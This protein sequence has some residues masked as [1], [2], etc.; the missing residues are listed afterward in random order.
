M[1]FR[2]PAIVFSA[3]LVLGGA[4]AQSNSLVDGT[5]HVPVTPQLTPENRGDIYMARKMYREAI[6]TFRLGSPT[7]AVLQNKIGIAYHQLSRLDDARKAYER[8]L[9]LNPTYVEAMNNL[10]T[11]YYAKKS[12][13]RAI[14]WYN[15]ALKLAPEQVKSAPIY[16]NLG[17]AW[18]ARKKYPETT[19]AY[20]HALALDPDVFERHGNFGV[21]LEERTVEERARY[22]L[23]LAKLYAKDGRNELALQYLRKA[24]EEGIKEKKKLDQEPEFAKL[25]NTPEF[26]QLMATEQRVL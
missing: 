6:E 18:F 11:V 23:Y 26:K 1:H 12:Y 10:G 15:K 9:R 7:S 4:F 3:S 16:M 14:S 20:E 13:R 17:T 8:A 24:L 2:I 5:K 25:R 21:M 22:H 19:K